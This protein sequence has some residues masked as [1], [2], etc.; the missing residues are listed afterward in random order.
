MKISIR[1]LAV[2][3][4][5]MFAAN[6]NALSLYDGAIAGKPETQGSL[7]YFS[8]AF[9][10]SPSPSAG[11]VTLLSSASEMVGYSNYNIISSMVSSSFPSLNPNLPTGFTLS[12]DIK[13]NSESHTSND[14]AG[15]SVILE[16]SD[17][18]GIELGF[19]N[20][21]IFAQTA[22]PLFTHG[23]QTT[24]FDPTAPLNSGDLFNHYDLN[25]TGGNYTVYADG[26]LILSG[27]TVNYDAVTTSD[28]KYTA[29]HLSNYVF[30]GD[31]TSEANA[32]TDIYAVSIAVPEPASML[33][34]SSLGGIVLAKRR[35]K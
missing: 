26:N 2:G 27:P 30:L 21:E 22:T 32:S 16:G 8:S 34:L 23:S 19:W 29:Y 13:V 24:N 5:G 4:V 33:L 3:L 15:F 12:F 18:K 14:R 7:S 31:D 25:I 11:K 1:I 6:A 10:P 20:D 28:L 17:K 9:S 35:R